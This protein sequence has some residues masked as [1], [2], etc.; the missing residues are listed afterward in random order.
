MHNIYGVV[1]KDEGKI[2]YFDGQDMDI[3][4]GNYVVVNT[5]K[6]IQYGKVLQKVKPSQV[7]IPSSEMKEIIRI[8]TEKDYDTYLSNLAEADKAMKKARELVD[9]LE[10]NMNILDVSY[11]LDK[12]QLLF[13]FVADERVD[14]RE[15]AKRLA[16]I[17]KTR[18]ELRQIGIRD[19]AKEIGGIGPC[20]RFLCCSTFLNDFSSVSIN[21]AKN[22]YIALN[23]TKING[24][25]GR[26]LCCFNYEDEQYIEMKKEYPAVGSY[27]KIDGEK[28]K[29]L[30]HNLFR[31]SYIVEKSTKE[32]VEIFLDESIK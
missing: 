12:K 27:I 3:E 4:I 29:V 18:I 32:Q 26:L 2:Y 11:T 5:E 21:M 16:A 10:L 13:N 8:A 23:P 6:G 28:A 31:R 20:G 22:Q 1:L 17:Y 15:L 9:E 25:C 7:K 30:T 14:F 19:K 24:A